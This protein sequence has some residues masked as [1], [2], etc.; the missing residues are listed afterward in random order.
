MQCSM[1]TRAN[2]K[3]ATMCS[4]LYDVKSFGMTQA[5]E[6]DILEKRREGRET[7]TDAEK[8]HHALG[9]TNTSVTSGI[10]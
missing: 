10:T 1:S 8:I 2:P 9:M 6:S 3:W 7:R 5:N 4:S